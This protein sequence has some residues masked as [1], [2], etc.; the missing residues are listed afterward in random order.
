MIMGV[1]VS[2]GRKIQLEVVGTFPAFGEIEQL[3]AIESS[4]S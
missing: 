3:H 2:G 4:T 1:L